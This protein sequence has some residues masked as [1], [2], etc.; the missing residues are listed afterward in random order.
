MDF[1][2][3]TAQKEKEGNDPSAILGY[4]IYRDY[5]FLFDYTSQRVEFPELIDM[6]TDFIGRLGD[7]FSLL[8]VEPKSSGSSLVQHLKKFTDLNVAEWTMADGDKLARAKS[9]TPFLR[10]GR[11]FLVNGPWVQGF[12]H[13]AT[14]FPRAAHDEAVDTLVMACYEAFVYHRASNGYEAHT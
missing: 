9:I 14:S 1:V 11:V 13:E 6:A 3:D 7:E 10:S 2:S 5:L 4:K 8:L 12:V